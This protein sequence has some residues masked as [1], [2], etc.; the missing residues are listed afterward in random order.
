LPGVGASSFFSPPFSRI[1][2]GH[3]ESMPFDPPLLA[4]PIPATAAAPR[5]AA[6]AKAA[7]PMPLLR[8]ALFL[9]VLL[10]S[11]GL[12]AA[13]GRAAPTSDATGF[14]KDLLTKALQ[15][16]SD[17][18]LS[19]EEK[20]KRFRDTLDTK[21]DMPRISRFVLGRYWKTAGDRDKQEFQ[22]LFED[23]V[24][25]AYSARFSQYSGE[26]VQ[27]IGARPESDTVTLVTSQIIRPN[28]APPAKIDWR[29][30]RQDNDL[31][32]VDID[33]EGVSMLVTQREE[34]GSVIQRS[35]GTVAGLNKTLQERLASG[36]T[37][38]AAPP[39]PQKQ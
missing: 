19:D 35:G 17:K 30:R 14:V 7:A 25:R 2:K 9:L 3:S 32:I 11:L 5:V 15:S 27:V 1:R 16:L 8:R 34:F 31:R 24:V 39:L 26:Q 4:P 6:P 21:F 13:S 28:G 18:S 10:A 23:Y 20:E 29:V 22:K 38:L 33:V 37:S 36:D 12:A